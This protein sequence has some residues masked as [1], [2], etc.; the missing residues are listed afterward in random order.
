[1]LGFFRKFFFNEPP[2]KSSLQGGNN[3]SLRFREIPFS[4]LNHPFMKRESILF[5]KGIDCPSLAAITSLLNK[6]KK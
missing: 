2:L 5:L 1:M 3:I 4:L 6:G